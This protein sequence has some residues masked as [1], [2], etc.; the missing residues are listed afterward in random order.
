MTRHEMETP[1]GRY[2]VWRMNW[3]RDRKRSMVKHLKRRER[4]NL[5]TYVLPRDRR[6][7]ILSRQQWQESLK[8]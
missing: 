5:F 4:E 1:L 3:W 8:S 2:R 7:A 6:M